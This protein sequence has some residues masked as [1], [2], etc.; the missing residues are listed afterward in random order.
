MEEN[1]TVKN[2]TDRIFLIAEDLEHNFIYLK[3]LLELKGAE[4]IWAQDG[5]KAVELCK[6]DKKIDM[7]LMDINLPKLSG[8]SAITQIKAF[9]PD[10][11]II[12]VTAYAY[13]GEKIKTIEA[14][15]DAFLTKPVK[16]ENLY[17]AI[18]IFF[19]SEH[20]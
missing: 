17:E 5:K 11:T 12:A 13:S 6:E 2:W 9:R 15:A 8:R 3:S 4:V 20:I 1:K 16:K 18:D 7:V 19:T 14:G 10:L